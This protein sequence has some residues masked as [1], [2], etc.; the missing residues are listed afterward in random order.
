LFRLLKRLFYKFKTRFYAKG[1]QLDI[2]GETY[3]LKRKTSYL[4]CK[5]SDKSFKKRIIKKIKSYK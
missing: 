4:I 5:E 3:G 1:K 2:I